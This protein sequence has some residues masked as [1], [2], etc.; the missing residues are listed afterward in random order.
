MSE[1]S[2]IGFHS[3]T[4]IARQE[5]EETFKV[6]SIL[7][8]TIFLCCAITEAALYFGAA[9]LMDVKGF[10]CQAKIGIRQTHHPLKSGKCVFQLIW[11][12]ELQILC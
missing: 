8:D 11:W 9:R 2:V 10:Y 12:V 7:K 3:D 4:R 6:V 1:D 5:V